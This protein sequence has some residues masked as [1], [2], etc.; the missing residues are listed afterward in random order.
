MRE[1]NNKYDINEDR[2]ILSH[3]AETPESAFGAVVPPLYLNSLHV[4]QRAADFA[5]YDSLEPDTYIYGRDGNPTVEL[6]ENKIAALERGEKALLFASGMAAISTAIMAA[7]QVGS[8][9]IC[10]RNIYGPVKQFIEGYCI[11]RLRMT[12]TY[13]KG[14]ET[15]EFIEAVK[16]ETSLIIVESPS[17][18]VFSLTNLRE[19]ADFA[20]SRGIKTMIDNTYCTPIFQKPLEMGID[21]VMHT[22]SKY[23]GGHSDVI[24]GVLVSKDQ[25]LIDDMK[26][27]LRQWFGGIAAPLEGWLI[28]RGMRTLE[29]RLLRHQETALVVAEFL[30]K[31][32]KVK[33]VYYPG[34]KSHPQYDLMKSQQLGNSGLLSFELDAPASQAQKL[35]DNLK[36]FQIG[37]SWGGFE[38]LAL[39][40]VIKENQEVLD[41]LDCGKGL[42]RLHCGLE[43]AEDLLADLETGLATL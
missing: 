13:V 21:I 15:A 23:L 30:E 37:C 34:L 27:T 5:N 17:T 28:L 8:H 11:P 22:A 41:F 40:P 43:G 19:L 38:S 3:Y 33:K 20:R 4:F 10:L 9:I 1:M 36:I 29:L 35:I 18:F 24:G 31:H 39:T 16:P 26:K 6:A 42:I 14:L 25:A 2:M 12:V 7:C 32:A